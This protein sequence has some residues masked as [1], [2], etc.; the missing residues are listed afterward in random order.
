VCALVSALDRG[1]LAGL[2]CGGELEFRQRITEGADSCRACVRRC[3]MEG[4]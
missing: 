3:S 4:K 2:T 1:L